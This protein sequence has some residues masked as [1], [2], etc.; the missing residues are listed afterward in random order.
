M[1]ANGFIYEPIF[2]IFAALFKTFGIKKD[3][4]VLF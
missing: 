2:K 3:D 4:M 1:D